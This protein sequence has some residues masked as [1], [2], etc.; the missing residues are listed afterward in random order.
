[1]EANKNKTIKYPQLLLRLAS[2]HLNSGN[3]EACVEGCLQAVRQFEEYDKDTAS[4]G[5]LT[6]SL[7]IKTF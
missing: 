4:G 2:L 1:M 6:E 5:V 7:K 3:I